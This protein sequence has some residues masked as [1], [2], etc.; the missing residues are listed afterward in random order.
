MKWKGASS[1]TIKDFAFGGGGGG[2]PIT[3]GDGHVVPGGVDGAKKGTTARG[4]KVG[5]SCRKR[6]G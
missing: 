3:M 2:Y 1:R 6:G 4:K 5:N